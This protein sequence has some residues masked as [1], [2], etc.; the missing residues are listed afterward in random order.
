MNSVNLVTASGIALLMMGASSSWAGQAEDTQG[1]YT[2]KMGAIGYASTSPFARDPDD[3]DTGLAPYLALEVGRLNVDISGASY[4]VYSSNGVTADALLAPRWVIADPDDTPGLSSL[5]RETAI[6]AGGRL[7][8]S[9]GNIEF[10]AA[11]L[12]DVSDTHGGHEVQVRVGTQW[13]MGER[14]FVGVEAVATWADS[15]LCTYT[16]GVRPGEA[17]VSLEAY[18]VKDSVTPSLGGHAGYRLTDRVSMMGGV[19]IEFLP[20]EVTSSPIVQRDHLVSTFLGVAY[21]F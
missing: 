21:A 10:I 17:T 15:A 4:T 2:L 11:Y 16:Y 13:E 18:T 19:R 7:A 9:V 14:A 12:G 8:Y 1:G 3:Y 5:E 6:E 20:D